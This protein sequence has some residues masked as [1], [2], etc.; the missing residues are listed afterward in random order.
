M[1]LSL[2]AAVLILLALLVVAAVHSW[3]RPPPDPAVQQRIEARV[4]EAREA[5]ERAES[6]ALRL[7]VDRAENHYGERLHAAFQEGGR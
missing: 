5:R 7:R 4:K 3:R 2:T 1:A 6:L